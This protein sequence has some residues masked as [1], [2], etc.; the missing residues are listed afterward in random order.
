[1]RSLLGVGLLLGLLACTGCVRRTLTI[2]T[3]P[4]G[5][6]VYVNDE[7]I[8][9]SPASTDFVWYGDYD[10]IVRKDGYQTLRTHAKVN[11]P[12]YQVPPVDFFA[13]VLYIGKLHDQHELAYTLESEQLPGP[14]E[15]IEHAETLRDDAMAGPR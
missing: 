12:W 2:R 15:V 10:I 3:E 11:P 1:M 6:L 5:A 4:A 9:R 8:G 13:E 14:D 7:E